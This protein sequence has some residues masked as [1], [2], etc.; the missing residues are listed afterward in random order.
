[1]QDPLDYTMAF[2]PPGPVVRAGEGGDPFPSGPSASTSAQERLGACEE[3][4][5]S[6]VSNMVAQLPLHD[7]Q[8]AV[9][10]GGPESGVLVDEDVP[11]CQGPLEMAVAK[12]HLG[13]ACVGE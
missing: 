1:M 4:P 12:K 7:C 5:R 9:C 13:E 8:Q 11:L 6:R 10:T 3:D 2:L